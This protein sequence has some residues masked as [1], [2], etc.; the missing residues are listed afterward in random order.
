MQQPHSNTQIKVG[1]SVQIFGYG[2]CEG[3]NPEEALHLFSGEYGKV[4]K[5]CGMMLTIALDD[6]DDVPQ[7]EVHYYQLVPKR[8]LI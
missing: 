6:P 1:D 2:V 5:Q 4:K 7:V 8:N 3:A